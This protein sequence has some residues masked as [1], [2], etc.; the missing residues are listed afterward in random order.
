MELKCCTFV[1][2]FLST[3]Q[4]GFLKIKI[5]ITISLYHY[6]NNV[7]PHH[8]CTMGPKNKDNVYAM[9]FGERLC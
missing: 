6:K 8:C 9:Q 4:N 1:Q 3:P 2:I 5:S 7:F